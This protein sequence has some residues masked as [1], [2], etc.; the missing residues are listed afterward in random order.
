MWISLII[1][2]CRKLQQ[3]V[4]LKCN[5]ST[6]EVFEIIGG[7]T[8]KDGFLYKKVRLES[9]NFWDVRPS[10][11]ELEQFKDLK[12]VSK[13][14]HQWLSKLY[15]E[16]RNNKSKEVNKVDNGKGSSLVSCD[17]SE[18]ELFDLVFFE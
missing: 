14:D 8:L 17:M 6:G 12:R 18:L 1:L 11:I 4:K 3:F 13:K 5:R 9:L 16:R 7:L 2:L 15:G 10:D